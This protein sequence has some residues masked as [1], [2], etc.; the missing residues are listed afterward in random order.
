MLVLPIVGIKK[1]DYDD[2]FSND[3]TATPCYENLFHHSQVVAQAQTD[4]QTSSLQ[5]ARSMF[6][7]GSWLS[8]ND[9]H[10]VNTEEYERQSSPKL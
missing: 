10:H 2:V 7:T 4:I 8:Q 3:I 5:S 9:W 6:N 1:Y